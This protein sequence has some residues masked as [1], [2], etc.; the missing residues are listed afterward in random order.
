MSDPLKSKV[1]ISSYDVSDLVYLSNVTTLPLM[2]TLMNNST[3]TYNYTLI[4]K[5]CHGV[6][7]PIA[8]VLDVD[9]TGLLTLSGYSSFVAAMHA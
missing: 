3:Y 2:L 5:V 6:K 7:A 1:V 4:S 9:S 8:Y